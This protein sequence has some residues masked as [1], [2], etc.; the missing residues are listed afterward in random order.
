MSEIC[1]SIVMS[2]TTSKNNSAAALN[3]TNSVSGRQQISSADM[4]NL[5]SSQLATTLSVPIATPSHNHHNHRRHHARHHSSHASHYNNNSVKTTEATGAGTYITKNRSSTDLKNS[6]CLLRDSNINTTVNKPMLQFEF[7]NN[8]YVASSSN[9]LPDN[10]TVTA[11]SRDEFAASYY[12]SCLHD[13]SP[14][15]LSQEQQIKFE[16]SLF[17]SKGDEQAKEN[18]NKSVQ[19][20]GNGVKEAA[21]TKTQGGKSKC[22]CRN[23]EK[24][25]GCVECT[26]H[27]PV[28]VRR[29]KDDEET[30]VMTTEKLENDRRQFEIKLKM[31]STTKTTTTLSEAQQQ[32]Q[33]MQMAP[34]IDELV[35]SSSSDATISTSESSSS[36]STSASENYESIILNLKP[37]PIPASSSL[38]ALLALTRPTNKFRA[39]PNVSLAHMNQQ[40]LF[41]NKMNRPASDQIHK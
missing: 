32:K 5:L 39:P 18:V 2:A 16:S 17:N 26:R 31:S 38:I 12:Q 36:C 27:Y 3:S 7:I 14:P 37:S 19:A 22:I 1:D 15:M 33:Q 30:R 25:F 34:L 21:K 13:W 40:E 41:D 28:S 10:D 11:T 9:S 6:E 4:L 23:N 8:A 35:E 29:S 24:H 20:N